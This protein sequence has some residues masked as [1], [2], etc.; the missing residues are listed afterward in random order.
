LSEW[1]RLIE[2]SEKREAKKRKSLN[3]FFS[4]LFEGKSTNEII[5]FLKR[6]IIACEKIVKKF[7]F[8]PH[9]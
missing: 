9:K 3:D 6:V 5:E 2:E 4:I 1:L 7:E 8:I